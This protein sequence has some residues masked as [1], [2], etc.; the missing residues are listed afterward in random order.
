MEKGK[1]NFKNRMTNTRNSLPLNEHKQFYPQIDGDGDRA[2]VSGGAKEEYN[3]SPSLPKR[4][5]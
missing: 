4:G 1:G 2:P 5:I 3:I